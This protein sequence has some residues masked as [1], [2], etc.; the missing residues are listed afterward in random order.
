MRYKSDMDRTNV[1]RCAGWGWSGYRRGV[2]D[3]ETTAQETTQARKTT[4]ARAVPLD[5]GTP[6]PASARTARVRRAP[7]YGVFLGTGGGLGILAAA[8]GGLSGPGD[9]SVGRGPLIGYLALMLGLLGA[10]IG[11]AAAVLVERIRR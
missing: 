9:P 2:S 1:P 6:D 11:G 7:R 5:H 10:L 8:I 4:Q 3:E